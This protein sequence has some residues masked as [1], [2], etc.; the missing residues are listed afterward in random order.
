M[1]SY[2]T[3]SS[4]A[5]RIL[6]SCSVLSAGLSP[7]FAGFASTEVFL[8]AVGRAPGNNGAQIYS[9]VWATNLTPATETFTFHFLKEGQSNLTSLAPT[10]MQTGRDGGLPLGTF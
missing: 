4:R 5:R 8:P 1:S 7:A 2:Q 10:R 3:L 9:T 6:L